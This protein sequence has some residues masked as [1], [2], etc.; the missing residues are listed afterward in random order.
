MA[1]RS[2]HR[3]CDRSAI[4]RRAGGAAPAAPA[5]QDA[6]PRALVRDLAE[7]ALGAPVVHEDHG[8]G[9]YRGL[10]TLDVGGDRR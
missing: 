7:L 5:Q 8:V 6:T 9:R 1:A 10:V 3:D 4:L 2:P